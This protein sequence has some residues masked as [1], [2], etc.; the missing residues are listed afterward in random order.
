MANNEPNPYADPKAKIYGPEVLKTL[1]YDELREIMAAHGE[2]VLAY[3]DKTHEEGQA[4]DK[5][6]DEDSLRLINTRIGRTKLNKIRLRQ[7]VNKLKGYFR[8]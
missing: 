2:G 7:N 6:T 3:F 4:V 8:R 5:W 1:D